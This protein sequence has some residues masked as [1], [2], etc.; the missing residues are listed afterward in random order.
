M[1][2]FNPNRDVAPV[3]AAAARWVRVCLVND[4][5]LFSDV[6]TLWTL[7]HLNALDRMF[8]QQPDNGSATFLEK[9]ERQLQAAEPACRQLMAE[10]LW[11]LMLFQSNVSPEKKREHISSIW[12]WSGEPLDLNCPLLNDPVLVGVGS[13]GMAYNSHRWRELAYLITLMRAFKRLDQEQ[14]EATVS[15]A[16]I[17]SRWLDGVP[18]EGYR[19]FRHILRYLCFPDVFE[20]ISVGRDKKAILTAFTGTSPLELKG[21]TD[22]QVDRRLLE[23]RGLLETERKSTDLDFYVGDLKDRWREQV[24]THRAW[25]LS[26]NPENWDWSSLIEDRQRAANGDVV[27]HNWRCSSR[28]VKEGDDVYLM[29]TGMAPRGIVA[30]GKV[31]KAP[32]EA[33]HY[34]KTRADAGER[35]WFIDAG[36]DGIRDATLDAI[37]LV[38]DLERASSGQTW[39]PQ[40]SGITIEPEASRTLSKLWQALPPLHGVDLD[41]ALNAIPVSVRPALNLILYGPPGTGK[42]HRLQVSYL[43]AYEQK[44]VDADPQAWI[45]T[46]V[47]GW[48]W[49]E[50]VFLTLHALGRPANVSEIIEHS[51]IR[52]KASGG[53]NQNIRAT[54]WNALQYHTPATST[55]VQVEVSRR[56]APYIFDKDQDG[57]WRLVGDWSD[58]CANL[59]EQAERLRRGPAGNDAPIRRYEFVTFHQSYAYEDFVEGIRP[60]VGSEGVLSYEVKPGLFRRLCSR[61]KAEP[62]HRY[63][64]FIDEIN[65]ANISKV[66]GE[67]IT[68]LEPDKRATYDAEGRLASGLEVTLP[69]SG[70]VFG[71]PANLDVY[72]TMNTADRSIALLDLALRRRFQFEELMPTPA[73]IPG[74]GDGKIPDGE[75]GEIDL[76]QLLE[77]INR[78]LA[79]LLHRDQTIGHAYFM[80][81]KDFEM[82]QRVLA[83]EI[84]PLLQEYFY[85]DWGRI[86]L[87]LADH[88]ARVETQIIRPRPVSARALFGASEELG[89]VKDWFVIPERDIVADAVRK[90]YEQIE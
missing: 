61:A 46:H 15:N 83:R 67:L 26:W 76:V 24:T 42:T 90:I 9:L 86:R 18:R 65:R 88:T 45:Q 68:L 73:A 50:V 10:A 79:Y 20:R 77:V 12:G 41:P 17:F 5:S 80:K 58:S 11:L 54:C 32:Y 25:L 85:E 43:P 16:W 29:R 81:I 64:L 70:E 19:Q 40:S 37:V 60:Q 49:W 31:M 33:P 78:R 55:R 38:N 84:V 21:W 14:R 3:L 8:V 82:L 28:H 52:A 59:V 35:T 22:E 53:D 6:K 63:A 69:Y 2:R 44:P 72:G 23:L 75:G 30:H 47:D 48:K 7:D 36:F 56:S 13:P 89:D 57:R 4:G 34:N 27:T 51:Y 71:V 74:T 66:F 62:L 87:V 39:S 1:T